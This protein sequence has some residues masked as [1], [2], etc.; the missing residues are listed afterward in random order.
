MWFLAGMVK[1]I[2]IES[3]PTL[4]STLSCVG[5]YDRTFVFLYIEGSFPK[6]NFFVT[7]NPRKCWKNCLMT[8]ALSVNLTVDTMC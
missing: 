7:R 2:R 4:E 3:F 6:Q 1:G 5:L 8:D